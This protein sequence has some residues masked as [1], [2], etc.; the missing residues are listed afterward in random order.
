MFGEGNRTVALMDECGTTSS[1]Q[2]QDEERT[3]MECTES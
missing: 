2:I 3:E 1:W